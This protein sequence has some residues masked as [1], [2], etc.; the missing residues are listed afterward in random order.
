MHA[1]CC[2]CRGFTK[3]F[4]EGGGMVLYV[5]YCAVCAMCVWVLCGMWYDYKG[6]VETSC[7]MAFTKD[8]YETGGLSVVWCVI[9]SLS[10]PP[11]S[12]LFPRGTA[13]L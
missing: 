13:G 9:R 3:G 6:A 12:A 4:F 8:E 5:Q 7:I 11:A 1:G 10:A 2:C